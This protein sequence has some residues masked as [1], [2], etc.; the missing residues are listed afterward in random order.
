MEKT[1]IL[2]IYSF[3]GEWSFEFETVKIPSE[4]YKYPWKSVSMVA[5]IINSLS[6]N[7]YVISWRTLVASV[8][9]MW[10]MDS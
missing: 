5:E 6:S 9:P 2:S 1:W 10:N 7:V 4:M 3:D 8:D